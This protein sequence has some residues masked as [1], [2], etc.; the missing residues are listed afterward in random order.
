[1]N[2][3]LQ[4]S[5][6]IGNGFSKFPL[7]LPVYYIIINIISMSMFYIDKQRAIKHQWR[8]SEFTLLLSAFIGGSIGAA[9][10][11]KLFRHKTKH[12]KFYI[13][14]PTFLIIHILIIIIGIIGILK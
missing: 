10:G 6:F 12:P 2:I 1:M 5:E 14:I 8:I 4:I 9:A 3:F 11:M 7:I 13:L